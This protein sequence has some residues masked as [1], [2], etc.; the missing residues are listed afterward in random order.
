MKTKYLW[1]LL[2][3]LPLSTCM[4]SSFL[5]DVSALDFENQKVG[6]S[7]KDLLTDKEF[8]CLT[9]EIQYMP[10]YKPQR[11]TV[12]NIVAFLKKYLHKPGGI[13]VSYKEV[14]APSTGDS[15]SR[16]DIVQI[17]RNNRTPFISKERI[18]IYLLFTNSMHPTEEILGMAYRNTSAV[19]YGKSIEE[20]SSPSGVLSRSE[21]E[22]AVVLH[23]IGHILGLVN[24]GSASRSDHVD[25]ENN[26]H[27]SNKL[28]LMYHA[29]ET[30]DLPTILKKG[31]IPVLDS[32]CVRDLVA[33][34]G[35][36]SY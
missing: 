34:G 16:D 27:C 26:Y 30:H 32:N 6:A 24:K 18:S 14:K 2:F 12:Y 20:N 13:N 11:Q 28:C 29:T 35:K 33:N 10:G 3:T 5:Q 19:I 36:A 9:V 15:L 1:L 8:E 23:E 22:T 4:K 25:E 21:L 31:Y 17:E 7:A